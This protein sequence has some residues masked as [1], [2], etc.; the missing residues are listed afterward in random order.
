MFYVL[1]HDFRL[2]L[3]P[4]LDD[5][6]NVFRKVNAKT[7]GVVA[8]FDHPNVGDAV[9]VLVLRE[10]LVQLAVQSADF[11]LQ[12][13]LDVEVFELT[14]L[15]TGYGLLVICDILNL[16]VGDL[17]HEH[18]LFGLVARVM[19]QSSEQLFRVHVGGLQ[20]LVGFYLRVLILSLTALAVLCYVDLRVVV[21][22]FLVVLLDE[23]LY[24]RLCFKD[25]CEYLY[26]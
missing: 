2:R 22:A 19:P 18:S 21:E 7:S 17:G 8:R 13:S 11:D 4:Q 1:L 23:F 20:R 6:L 10:E 26:N 24:L 12:V 15:E 14:F 16:I 25:F 3:F 5:I 9:D